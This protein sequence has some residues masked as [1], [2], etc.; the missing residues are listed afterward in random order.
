ML[1]LRVHTLALI[2]IGLLIASERTSF[3]R[4]GVSEPPIVQQRCEFND[5][6]IRVGPTIVADRPDGVSSDGRGA[7][8]STDGGVRMRVGRAAAE[9]S[10]VG[11][12]RR[13]VVNLRRPV[14][15]GGGTP[16]GMITD[17]NA[18]GAD[19]ELVLLAQ[20]KMVGDTVQSPLGIRVGETVKA[21]QMN[22]LFHI[23][24]RFH[25]LQMGPLPFGKC[26]GPT[27]VHGN[28]TSQGTIHRSSQTRWVMDLPTGSVGRLFDVSKGRVNAMDL[29]TYFVELHYEMVD[30]V[31]GVSN[32]LQGM[33]RSESAPAIVARYRAMK[34]DSA[35]AYLFGEEELNAVGYW[36]VEHR[37]PGEALIIFR[38]N[39]EEFPRSANAFYGLGESYLG[40][41]D[42]ANAIANYKRFLELNPKDQDAMDALRRLGIKP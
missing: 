32:L 21:E 11:P 30:A 28:G 41:L 2:G 36:L 1:S 3:A 4:G 37:R 27:L 10:I 26:H 8:T 6:T 25:A 17:G 12:P 20:W 31:L 9:M 23:D 18:S 19:G 42:T 29:G 35:K 38:L 7:Y 5:Q 39:L 16:R 33:A 24:G 15:G 40:V 34:R 13:L 14:P 22:V